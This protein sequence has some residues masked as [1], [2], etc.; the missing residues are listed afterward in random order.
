[1]TST[2]LP[3]P[4]I[5][6]V[7]TLEEQEH[8]TFLSDVVHA[9]LQNRMAIAG[10]SMVLFLAFIAVFV[11]VLS[12]HDPYLVNLDHQLLPPSAKYWLG[13]DKFG[14][15]LLTRIMYGTRISLVIGLVPSLLSMAIGA[16]MGIVSGYYGGKTDFIIMRF[17]DVMI[18]FPSLLL[19]MV[20]MYTLGASLFNIF[21]ALSL[22]GWAGTARVVRSQTLSLKEKEF[23]EAARAIGVKKRMIMIKHILPNCLPVL[24]VLFSLRIP[25]AIM[26]ESSLSFLGVG[27]QPPTPSWGLLVSQGKEYL[28]S[29]P[30]VAIMPGIA[31]LITVLAFNFM[32]DGIRDALDPYMKD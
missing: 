18:A 12:P 21:I 26:Y 25:E 30:W 17:A 14:R 6:P 15:D 24:I 20:V 32:G 13:T 4:A 2:I 10:L 3:E 1:M 11:P 16:V 22:V 5:N 31:I 29:A 19:A 23:V 28:F 9:F 8:E 27:A 7:E